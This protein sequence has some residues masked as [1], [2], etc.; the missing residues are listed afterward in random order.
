MKTIVCNCGHVT[1]SAGGGYAIETCGMCIDQMAKGWFNTHCPPLYADTDVN[2]LDQD[3]VNKASDYLKSYESNGLLIV[4]RSRVGKTR[5]MWQVLKEASG[6][7]AY[8]HKRRPNIYTFDSTSF[9]H[10]LAF[11]YRGGTAEEWVNSVSMADLV[12]FDDLGKAKL[13]DR[14]ESELFGVIERR[15]AWKRPI[16]ATTEHTPE[17]LKDRVSEHRGPAMVNRLN[18]CCQAILMK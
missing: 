13:T 1:Q 18:E 12:A 4:G 3:S 16:I 11:Q 10:E 6:Y 2:R 9:G 8:Q 7:C 15:M 14:A 5:L 17:G